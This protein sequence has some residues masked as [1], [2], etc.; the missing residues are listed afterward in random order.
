MY[1]F[2]LDGTLIG[3]SFNGK[4]IDFK[5][6]KY[7]QPPALKNA[8]GRISE[9]RQNTHFIIAFCIMIAAFLQKMQSHIMWG[10]MTAA[11]VFSRRSRIH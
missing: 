7:N 11:S 2:A 3:K 4:R 8:A 10:L 6:D 1:F 9:F 5:Y